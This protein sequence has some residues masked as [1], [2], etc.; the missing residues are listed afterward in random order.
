MDFSDTL[1]AA[2]AAGAAVDAARNPT[3]PPAPGEMA[4]RLGEEI[5][6]PLS[7]AL[8][9]LK[10]LAHGGPIDPVALDLLRED[11]ERA[12]R[13]GIMGQQFG[14]FAAGRLRQVP[15]QLDLALALRDVL[16]QRGRETDARGIEI[17]QQLQPASV[18]ADAPLVFSLLQTLLD[19]AIEHS[20]SRIDLRV[21][22]QA[23]PVQA[24]LVCEFG[25][26]DVDAIDTTA[27]AE[28]EHRREQQI[29][30]PLDS[31]A[32]GLLQK[33]AATLGLGIERDST[34]SQAVVEIV[35]PTTLT[36]GEP[37]VEEADAV[38]EA[39]DEPAFAAAA[40]MPPVGSHV[41]VVAGQRELRN[42]VRESL[43]RFAVM[44]DFAASIDEA[45]RF[46]S[47]GLPQ[48][49]VY[50]GGLAGAEPLRLR[51]QQEL[52]SLAFIRV[53]EGGPAVEVS[54]RGCQGTTT[55]SREAIIGSLPG[56]LGYEMGR[57]H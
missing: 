34:A 40:V 18:T 41:L 32:W 12:R 35:F 55:V 54:Q 44:L 53:S 5:A 49:I 51:L 48:A 57:M 6:A 4:G 56:A 38:T 42:A 31:V 37:T 26:R 23:W 50:E 19:W 22:M 14:R 15:E 3:L 13:V 7:A 29:T 28:Y 8:E 20:R 45:G 27:Q 43:R 2:M 17:R 47:L 30:S 21:D 39:G 9:R 52:P 16:A 46:C 25:Y 36:R 10:H 11:I 33:I 24:R 1:S